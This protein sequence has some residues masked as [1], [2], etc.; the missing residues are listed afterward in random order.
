MRTFRSPRGQRSRYLQVTKPVNRPTYHRW[1]R[2]Q[3]RKHRHGENRRLGTSEGYPGGEPATQRER[4]FGGSMRRETLSP[5]AR[6]QTHLSSMRRSV[7]PLSTSSSLGLFLTVANLFSPLHQIYDCGGIVDKHLGDGLMAV[8]YS[9]AATV[10][11]SGK[12]L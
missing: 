3:L 2:P 9:L 1:S 6:A 7:H 5:H 4:I 10:T 11:A 12:A 8:F